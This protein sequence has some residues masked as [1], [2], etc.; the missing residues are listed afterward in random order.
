LSCSFNKGELGFNKGELGFNKGELVELV[1]LLRIP[2]P[3]V[4]AHRD[5]Y[6]AIE[7]LCVFLQSTK[8]SNRNPVEGHMESCL[9]N[10]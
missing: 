2:Q 9:E 5:S 6:D 10:S 7:A 1:E 4:T 8:I 3:F